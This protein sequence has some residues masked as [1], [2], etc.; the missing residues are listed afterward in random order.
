MKKKTMIMTCTGSVL[1]I[2]VLIIAIIVI[3]ALVP[4]S[5]QGNVN[6]LNVSI[7]DVGEGRN[8]TSASNS[9]SS[10]G[11]DVTNT[12]DGQSAMNVNI[13]DADN[14]HGGSD[15]SENADINQQPE[16]STSGDDGVDGRRQSYGQRRHLDT[17]DEDASINLATSFI[18][19][20]LT[21]DSSSLSDGTWRKSVLNYVDAALLNE[22]EKYETNLLYQYYSDPQWAKICSTYDKFYSKVLEVSDPWL[23]SEQDVGYD[24]DSVMCYVTVKRECTS[25]LPNRSNGWQSVNIEQTDYCISMTHD[26]SKVYRV[27][28]CGSR[29]LEEDINN[30]FDTHSYEG[31]YPD[32]PSAFNSE[33]EK[34]KAIEE[35]M[36]SESS[37]Y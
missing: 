1:A 5:Q 32:P 4:S 16:T 3:P 30:W 31:V 26:G 33:E 25:G 21:F 6:E 17:V 14:S 7:G 29:V 24:F 34:Q 10:L 11:E 20:F 9:V 36:K 2:V 12:D 15:N 18:K 28:E 23:S 19:A 35:Y 8:G 13:T 37:M 27:M 22:D